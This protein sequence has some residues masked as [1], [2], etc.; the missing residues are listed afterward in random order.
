L[1]KYI[2]IN[3]TKSFILINLCAV[4]YTSAIRGCKKATSNA[5]NN[6]TSTGS[7]L[8]SK[9]FASDSNPLDLQN[10]KLVSFVKTRQTEKENG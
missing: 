4:S 2:K 9:H 8:K 6:C 10:E 1:Q 3:E 7:V 5:Q